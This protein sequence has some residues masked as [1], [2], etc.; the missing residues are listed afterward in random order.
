M[1]DM[2]TYL[3]LFPG[4]KKFHA[5]AICDK[6]FLFHFAAYHEYDM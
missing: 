1:E 6:Q 3:H 5:L 2:I 4:T